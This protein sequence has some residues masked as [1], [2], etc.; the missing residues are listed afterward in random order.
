MEDIFSIDS[1]TYQKQLRE[2]FKALEVKVKTQ[3][4]KQIKL[5][6]QQRNELISHVLSGYKNDERLL[7]KKLEWEG[8]G[9]EL[10]VVKWVYELMR[11]KRDLYGYFQN[12][13]EIT[14]KLE[15]LI[16][17]SEEK[18]L[19]EI[20]KLLNHWYSKLIVNVLTEI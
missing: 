3:T 12:P 20:S 5:G 18:E 8:T 10:R 7:A 11:S 1:I 9:R 14:M 17:L 19:Y 16:K 15:S 13:K 6:Y 2:V 4:S